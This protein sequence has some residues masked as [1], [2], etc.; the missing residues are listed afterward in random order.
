MVF[1]ADYLKIRYIRNKGARELIIWRLAIHHRH[2][3]VEK[4]MKSELLEHFRS[5]SREFCSKH[6]SHP[7][8]LKA[9]L[10]KKNNI[11]GKI[12]CDHC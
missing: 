11:I 4:K 10:S 5:F 12:V 7:D 8:R 1:G 3:I 2:P 6:H 9:I